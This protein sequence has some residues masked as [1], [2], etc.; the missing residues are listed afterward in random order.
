MVKH[1]LAVIP[2]RGGSKRIPKKNIIDFLGRPMIEWTIEAAQK[3]NCFD[4]ILVSTD[5]E[6]IAEISRKA[7]AQ[8]PFLRN[9]HLDDFSPISLATTLALKQAESHWNIKFDQVVQLMANCPLRNSNDIKKAIKAFETNKR[10]FQI[11]CFRFGWMNPWW[12]AKL[13]KNG[14]PDHVFSKEERN[15]RSQDQETLFCPTGSIWIANGQDLKI[16]NDFY[17]PQHCFEELNWVSAVDIDNYEDIAFAV[18]ASQF[19]LDS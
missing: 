13:N 17:G 11:S 19:K 2:A 15:K 14:T 6:E 1:R 12:A 4:H 7:G 5:D 10:L 8:V 18:A 16:S 3:S 9:H